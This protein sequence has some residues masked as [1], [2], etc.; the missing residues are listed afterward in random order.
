MLLVPHRPLDATPVSGSWE[1]RSQRGDRFP[2]SPTFSAKW[3]GGELFS[4]DKFG[5]SRR[6]AVAVER[7]SFSSTDPHSN[8]QSINFVLSFRRLMV[9]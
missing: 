6:L 1:I 2:E 7:H 3:S 9:G 8:C 5:R 4:E